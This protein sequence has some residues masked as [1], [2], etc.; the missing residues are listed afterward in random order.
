MKIKNRLL[1]YLFFLINIFLLNTLTY[2][3]SSNIEILFTHKDNILEKLIDIIRSSEKN[4][5][6]AVFELNHERI[7]DELIKAKKRGVDVNIVLDDRAKKTKEIKPLF[8]NKIPI[9]FDNKKSYMHNKILIID[10]KIAITGSMNLTY[11]DINQNRNNLVIVKNEKIARKYKEEFDEMFYKKIFG[12]GE[13][14][15]DYYFKVDE[16]DV[17]IFFSPEEKVDQIIEESIN[18]A[19]K[20]LFIAAFAL[21]HKGIIKKIK[22]L[23]EKI[24]VKIVLDRH[25]AKNENSIYQYPD[26]RKFITL[27]NGKGKMHHKFIIIDNKKVITGSFNFSKNATE[28]NDENIMVLTDNKIVD[29]F[30]KEFEK[31][32]E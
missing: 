26:L 12:K 22:D 10:D 7:I 30:K 18:K 15:K 24:D 20:S 31:L 19:K 9:V 14:T 16:V 5:E 2:T 29:I 23:S 11:N 21:T 8:N 27:Y 32:F 4:I 28:K 25:Q 6:I 1:I 13:K 17:N 3:A